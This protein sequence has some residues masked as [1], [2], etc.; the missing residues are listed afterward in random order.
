MLR[1]VRGRGPLPSIAME[2]GNE[3]V[4]MEMTPSSMGIV[5]L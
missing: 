2:V 1:E 4:A 5:V 3:P